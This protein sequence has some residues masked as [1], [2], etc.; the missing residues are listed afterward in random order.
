MAAQAE[1]GASPVTSD[2]Q[3]EFEDALAQAQ[4]EEDSKPIEP[5]YVDGKLVVW[6]PQ[7]GS[8]EE[9]MSCPLFECLYHGTRGGGKTDALIMDF[10]QDVGKGYGEAWRGILFRET[11]PQL[12]DVVAKSTRWFRQIFPKARFNKSRMAWEWET[13]EVL[14]LRHMKH[15][16]DYWNY[17]GHEYPWIGFEELTNW[18]DDR[19]YKSMFACCRSS[20]LPREAP[21]KIRATTNPYG[22]GH[23]WVKLRFR[24]AG[25]WQDTI[26]VTDSRDLDG[27]I[28]K[29]R[30]AIHSHLK[31]NR[32]LLETDPT[33][34][35]TIAG[36]ALN[37]AMAAAW[38]RGDWDVV[39]GG[40]FD[41]VWSPEF[42]DVRRFEIPLTWR[43]DRAFDWGSSAP[44]SV[45]WYAQS[46]GSDLLL[47][48][49]RLVS[50]IR[51]DLFR[52]KEWY[53]WTGRPNEGT[54]SLATEVTEGIVEREL[55]WGY[56]EI[57]GR[58][59][60]A[61]PG[62]ADSSIYTVENG[63]SIGMDMERPVRINGYVYSGVKWTRADKSPGSRVAGWERM[64][65][66]LKAAHPR[67][68]APREQP[69]LFIVGAECEQ[70]LRTVLTLPRDQKNLDDVDTDAEDHIADEV[71]YRVRAG[72]IRPSSGTT[73][74]S[75]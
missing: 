68:G 64:R 29:P 66:M 36:A 13:G 72:F 22:V 6:A 24:L 75:H 15:P 4:R 51:G 10:A 48:D 39:A 19:C 38:L 60:R 5:R 37:A 50:T 27:N 44:F 42:N 55:I 33:Y 21:R 8:Q 49:G 34:E 20:A 18:A 11:Y 31:E 70:F 58:T 54:R 35:Q 52:I 3:R 74:G 56:R 53:G 43:I 61:K 47:E 16:D 32:I 7:A 57:G 59:S 65:K 25:R 28:E 17:H 46:D 30:A 14:L 69:A 71:R 41:D 2:E 9:F 73:V 67:E 45:G 23:G 1:G 26:V 63:R 62:P 40:M 12:A